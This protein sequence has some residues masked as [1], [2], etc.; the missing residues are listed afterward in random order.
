MTSA[1]VAVE[2]ALQS[3]YSGLDDEQ[4]ARL[5]RDTVLS[6]AQVREGE[7]VGERSRR[8]SRRSEEAV[9]NR[10][11]SVLTISQPRFEIGL[12]AR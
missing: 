8:R 2:P 7:R 4:K 1:F 9:T 5:L 11:A 3:F 6:E 10:E 12:S